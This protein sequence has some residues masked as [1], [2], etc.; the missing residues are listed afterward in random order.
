MSEFVN[1][2]NSVKVTYSSGSG[3]SV[4][5]TYANVKKDVTADQ[6]AA[7]VSY[8]ENLTNDY[9]TAQLVTSQYVSE[10]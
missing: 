1:K 9:P 4:T 6:L 5:K 2:K 3:K 10:G 7:L 8:L